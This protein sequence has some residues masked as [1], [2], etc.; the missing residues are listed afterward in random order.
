MLAGAGGCWTAKAVLEDRAA[1]MVQFA[2]QHRRQPR[3]YAHTAP[4]SA[5][6]FL[7]AET[8]TAAFAMRGFDSVCARPRPS[9]LLSRTAAWEGGPPGGAGRGA[10]SS[11]M[12]MAMRSTR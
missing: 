6:M 8:S 10:G 3:T 2:Q 9:P 11:H 12:H 5:V 1:A 4:S 7:L